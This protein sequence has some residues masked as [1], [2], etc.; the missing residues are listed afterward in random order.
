MKDINKIAINNVQ[1]SNRVKCLILLLPSSQFI[2][3]IFVTFIN[4][5]CNA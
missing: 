4:T 1:G 3:K 5:F 2:T